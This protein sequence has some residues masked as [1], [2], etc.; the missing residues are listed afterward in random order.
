[1]AF[2]AAGCTE[3][4][5]GTVINN[6]ASFRQFMQGDWDILKEGDLPL[7]HSLYRHVALDCRT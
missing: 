6:V 2:A 7:H 4:I 5:G 3:R 1:M